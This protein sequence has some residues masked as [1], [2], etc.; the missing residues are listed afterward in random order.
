MKLLFHWNNRSSL[1]SSPCANLKCINQ[2]YFGNISPLDINSIY[3][4]LTV[5]TPSFFETFIMVPLPIVTHNLECPFPSAGT[6]WAPS[7]HA[8]TSPVSSFYVIIG[9]YLVFHKNTII[10]PSFPKSSMSKRFVRVQCNLVENYMSGLPPWLTYK[11][12]VVVSLYLFEFVLE[13]MSEFGLI[14]NKSFGAD[15]L[16]CSPLNS[17]VRFLHVFL[18]NS[19]Y[20]ITQAFSSDSKS[21]VIPNIHC[22]L[23]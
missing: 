16:R 23:L 22:A 15:Y 9:K 8:H 2:V 19:Y 10:H 14:L 18:M 12:L 6:A 17:S 21:K 13:T 3:V 7:E 1:E 4:D 20:V 11:L 5:T